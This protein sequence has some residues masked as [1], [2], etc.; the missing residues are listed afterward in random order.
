MKNIGFAILLISI[1]FFGC[2]KTEDYSEIP[3][4]SFKD[5]N[6]DI[7]IISSGFENQVGFLSFD[8]IDGNGDIGFYGNSDSIISEEIPD[9]F[10]FEYT[11]TNGIFYIT[12]TIEYLLP[13]F[14][15]GVY[16]KYIKGEMEVK[17][18]F[19]NRDTDTIKYD[20]QIMDRE[21]HLSNIEST[22]ELVVPE[23]N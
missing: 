20:F 17:L 19:I 11:K 10:I 15:E 5:F 22:P 2:E 1:L 7:E 3:S 9:I 23:W 4:I 12:D 18:Y 14:E 6:F 13:Y 16:R 8:F 21:Y